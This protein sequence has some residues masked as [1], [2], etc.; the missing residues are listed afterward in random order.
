MIVKGSGQK[1]KLLD[2]NAAI[3]VITAKDIKNSGQSSTAE[4]ISSIPGVVNQKAGSKTYFSIRG[5]R[6]GMSGGPRIFLDGRPLNV[7]AYDY[8]K[9]DSIPLDNIEKIEVIKSPSTAKYGANAGRG[10]I[11]ITT[12]SGAESDKAFGGMVSGEY[13]SWDTT[14]VNAGINGKSKQMDYS[15]SAYSHQSEGYR[16]DD[17]DVK[18]VDGQ[19]GWEFDGGRIDWI[20]GFNQAYNLYPPG[21]PQWQLDRD[22]TVAEFNYEEDG[23]GYVIL[24]NETDED[25]ISTILKVDYDKNNWLFNASAG[26]SQDHQDFYYRKYLNSSSK[27]DDNY[28]DDRTENIYD[29]KASIGKEFNGKSMSN[30]L[31]FGVDYSHSDFDQER[32]YPFDTEGNNTSSE[33][34]ADIDVKKKLFGANLNHDLSW[35]IFRFQTGVRYNNVTYELSNQIPDS[36]KVDFKE[37]I[38]WHVSPSVNMTSNSNLF[39]SW[40]HSH[41]YLPVGHYK[42]NMEYGDPNATPQGLKPETYDTVEA[43]WKH[44][45]HKAFNYSIIAYWTRIDDRVVSYYNT[46]NEYKGRTN[47]GVSIHQGIEVEVDGRPFNWMGYRVSFTTI[48]AEWDKG[49]V[50]AYETPTE[51]AAYVVTQLG[52]KK[53]NNV[54]EYEY[55][56][57]MDFFPVRNSAY[58][59][60]TFALDLRGFGEQYADYNNNITMSDAHFLDAKITWMYRAVEF[61]VACTNIF[62]KEWDKIVNARGRLHT[63]IPSTSAPFYPQDGRYIGVGAAYRF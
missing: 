5:T 57:G 8:S 50:K 15:L 49:E 1:T 41:F 4:L 34:K 33:Q 51:D 24:P 46:S 60:F 56:V 3:H 32:E 2:A 42:S 13:G 12:K 27:L 26:F 31:I 7:G 21:L 52:G 14:K 17:R 45:M 18:S 6:T 61:Y 53:V 40:N 23:S 38:D 39:T 28:R 36:V 59:S 25:L 54:P 44:Q 37:D 47:A 29:V 9:I 11:L 58:G 48:D 20:T 16:H 22:R 62:D 63:D 55:T 30:T 19:V 10:V 35:D 43:G